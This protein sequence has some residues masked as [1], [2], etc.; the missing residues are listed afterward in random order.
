MCIMG[1]WFNEDGKYIT[2]GEETM[3]K[4]IKKV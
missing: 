4:I 3:K 1:K 2:Q